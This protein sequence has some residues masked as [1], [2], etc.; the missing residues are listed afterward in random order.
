MTLKELPIESIDDSDRFRQNYPN[1]H[2]LAEDIKVNGL[3]QP[4]VVS[5]KKDESGY[6]LIAGGRRLRAMRYLEWETA[7]CL[8]TDDP[9]EELELREKELA[10]N[11]QREDMSFTERALLTKRIHELQI[12]KH[13]EARPGVGGGHSI[14]QTAE[15]MD[16]SRSQTHRLLTIADFIEKDPEAFSKV[17]NQKEALALIQKARKSLEARKNATR[18]AKKKA[19]TPIDLL[20]KQVID[21]YI[22]EDFFK[23]IKDTPDE[24]VDFIEVDPPYGIDLQVVRKSDG[25]KSQYAERDYNEIPSE[26]YPAF[27]AKVIEECYRVLKRNRWMIFW[28]AQEPWFEVVYKAISQRFSTTRVVGVW[29]KERSA[30]Q[31]LNP[32]LRLPNAYEM[33]FYAN[34]GQPE[35]Y[36]QHPNIFPFQS[37]PP[38]QKYHPTERPIELMDQLI[39]TFSKPG[40][41]VLVPFLGSGVTLLSAFRLDR[42]G[43]G[44]D[45]TENFKNHFIQRV[46][47]IIKPSEVKNE[48]SE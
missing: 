38:Q 4:I 39:R 42:T 40:D 48:I 37:V 45:L 5:P 31:T 13:G 9:V 12:A 24:S 21:S 18:I 11:I 47:L 20:R 26:H 3:I 19:E 29:Y 28:T 36:E 8:V 6:L 43:F 25:F 34:K 16:Q 32:R 44:F 17:Q 35:I 14:D 10:E 2:L 33:F 7:P 46:P 30:M 41:R 22:I 1:L 15:F 27:L 23:G